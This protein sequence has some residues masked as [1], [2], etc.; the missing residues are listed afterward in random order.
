[1]RNLMNTRTV[2]LDLRGLLPAQQMELLKEQYVALRGT[3]STVKARVD[4]L[5]TRPY[6]SLLERGYRVILERDDE[7]TTLILRPDGSTPRLGARG[8]HSVAFHQSGKLY[9]N[10]TGDRIAVLDASTRK[11]TRHIEV[12]ATPSHL[13]LS[14]D[15]Q[16]LYVANSGSNDVSIIDT[17]SDTLTNSVT[18]GKNPILPCVA[19]GR[20]L[21]YIPSGPDGTVMAM[22]GTGVPIA[23]IPVGN[24]PHDIAVSPD[25]RWAYQPNSGSHTV[26]VID[27]REQRAVVEVAVGL[28]PGHV[29]FSPDSR[30]AY[31]ANTLS[32]DVSVL[33]TTNHE[34]HTTIPAGA[35]AHL[36]MLSPDGH[37]GCVANFAAD[38]VTVWDTHSH[39][40][41]ARI[42]VG[43]Y[44]H[45]LAVSPN[46]EWIVASNT[47]EASV[48][49]IAT[50]N[51]QVV[52]VLNVGGAPAHI[53]FDPDGELA[54]VG[55]ERS[56]D[57]AIIDLL[58]KRV[59]DKVAAGGDRTDA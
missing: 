23:N 29:A 35:G 7:R 40:V 54:F 11:V 39:Q 36:P 46:S 47:G 31:V 4:E 51:F 3:G 16:R 33:D 49:L 38:D 42:P 59:L 18:T 37:L 1:M 50:V 20:D 22:D 28:G 44:P 41:L 57:V 12:G 55:C 24:S 25:S 43:I 9:T 17:F 19:P 52:A 34:V 58:N 53:A 26:T 27:T 30:Y 13:E 32:D 21:V 8:A 56:D 6:I 10:T 5:P 2:Q 15:G 48:C 14:H 45:F